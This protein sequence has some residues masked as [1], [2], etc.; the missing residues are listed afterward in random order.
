MGR[1]LQIHAAPARCRHSLLT[2]TLRISVAGASDADGAEVG[3]K[4][5]E[6]RAIDVGHE[7]RVGT[8][9]ARSG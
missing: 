3:E 2:E 9:L 1:S 6:R 8:W 7:D 4:L 5:V